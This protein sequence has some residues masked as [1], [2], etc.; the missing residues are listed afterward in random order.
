MSEIK[1]PCLECKHYLG[2]RNVLK[3]PT[4]KAFPSGIPDDVFLGRIEHNDKVTGQIGKY[5]FIKNSLDLAETM[6]YNIREKVKGLVHSIGKLC[7][8][9]FTGSLIIHFSQGGVA[10][11]ERKDA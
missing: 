1:P 11:I 6:P 3:P 2:R 8:S 5:K 10:R 9:R 7:K 4:C